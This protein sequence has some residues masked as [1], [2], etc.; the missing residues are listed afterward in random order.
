MHFRVQQLPC[1]PEREVAFALSSHRGKDAHLQL[2]RLLAK[3]PKQ[4]RLPLARGRLHEQDGAFPGPRI[5]QPLLLATC[6]WLIEMGPGAGPAG[7]EIIF[8]GLPEEL[9]WGDTPTAPY[10]LEVLT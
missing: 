6:D 9:A 10:L 8:E 3:R 1:D 7:G 5:V 4:R 2:E